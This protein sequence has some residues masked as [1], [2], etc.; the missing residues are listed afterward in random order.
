MAGGGV[1]GSTQVTGSLPVNDVA[2]VHP[3]K[4][5]AYKDGFES[6]KQFFNSGHDLKKTLTQRGCRAFV[7]SPK[8]NQSAVIQSLEKQLVGQQDYKAVLE[9]KK[10]IASSVDAIKQS[11]QTNQYEKMG[12]EVSYEYPDGRTVSVIPPDGSL[13]PKELAKLQKLLSKEIP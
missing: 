8:V 12:P 11:L 9:E 2:G 3:V 6:I 4:K 1:Q 10:V 13:S 5:S 7:A